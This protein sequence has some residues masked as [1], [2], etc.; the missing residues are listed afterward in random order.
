MISVGQSVRWA[1]DVILVDLLCSPTES[2]SRRP[3]QRPLLLA[4][5]GFGAGHLRHDATD[6]SRARLY[7]DVATPNMTP[8]PPARPLALGL[9]Q[10]SPGV[11]VAIAPT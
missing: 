11:S 10:L 7:I 5:H 8:L 2:S 4:V 9:A 1:P 6:S 3:D